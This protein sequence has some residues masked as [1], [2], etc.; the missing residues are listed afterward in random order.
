MMSSEPKNLVSRRRFLKTGLGAAATGSLLRFPLALAQAAEPTKID[1]ALGFLAF[2]RWAPL[3]Y[4][5]DR[6]LYKAR[7]LDVGI[8]P[9]SGNTL[10][11]QMLSAGRAQFCIADLMSLLQVQGSN[12]EPRMI[13]MAALQQKAPLAIFYLKGGSINRPKD[14]AGKTIVD[15]PG[16]NA[17][18]LMPLFAAANGFD[19]NLVHWQSVSAAAKTALLFQ[20]QAEAVSTYILGLPGMLGKLGP[21]QELG[22]FVYGDYGV[23]VY[24]DGIVTTQEFLD[25]NRTAARAFVQVTCQAYQASLSDPKAATA[26]VAAMAKYVPT[27]DQAVALKELD[28]VKHLAI[29]PVQK[30][31]PLGYLDPARMQ[32]SYDAVVRL[33]GQP[34]SRPV[35]DL[36]T[37]EAF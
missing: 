20:G 19:P 30:D 5:L 9:L 4:A 7:G 18:P 21:K 28:I 1:V 6:G 29:G 35:T 26:A 13:A 22:Y 15:S 36:Y 16:G 32:A 23:N 10:A 25:K 3:Y 31:H 12:P 33:I 34:I 8:K 17:K 24:G 27:L 14:L 37:N 2:G 11:F